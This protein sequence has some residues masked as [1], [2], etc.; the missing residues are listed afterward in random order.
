[1]LALQPLLSHVS[2]FLQPNSLHLDPLPEL[3]FSDQ[4]LDRFKN[5]FFPLTDFLALSGLLRQAL[6][7]WIKCEI[8]DEIVFNYDLWPLHEQQSEL[9]TLEQEWLSENSLDDYCLS[10]ELLRRKLLVKPAMLRW[11]H[12]QWSNR[13]E[14]L[15]LDKKSSLDKASCQ[16]IRLN[17]KNIAMEIYHQILEEEISFE[18]ASLKYGLGEERNKGGN[19]SLRT[20]DQMPFGLAPILRKL[21]PGKLTLPLRL[22]KGFAIVRMGKLVEA[23]FDS[24]ME[25]FLLMQE[26]EQWLAGT[27]DYARS[28]LKSNHLTSE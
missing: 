13:L 11:S 20:L 4:R 6:T 27:C 16:L 9:L 10:L 23:K 15:Y 19:L 3:W 5:T 22:G 21:K 25:E 28:I 8:A 24:T 7:Y 18:S 12:K 14:T 26:L 17:S 1:M 2:P